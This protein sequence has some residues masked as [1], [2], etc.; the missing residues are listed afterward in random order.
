MYK[1]LPSH[2]SLMRG[3]MLQYWGTFNL[4]KISPFF[5]TIGLHI[6]ASRSS[7]GQQFLIFSQSNVVVYCKFVVGTSMLFMDTVDVPVYSSFRKVVIM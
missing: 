1:Y 2:F 6:C 3:C 5:R 7:L 4:Q